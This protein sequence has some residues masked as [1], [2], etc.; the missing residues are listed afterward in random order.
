M[1]TSVSDSISKQVVLHAPRARVWRALTDA[2]EFGAWFGVELEG[3][4]A[5]GATVHG[6]VALRA[7]ST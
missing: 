1:T 3:P 7:T 5:E 4:F 2:R 6:R